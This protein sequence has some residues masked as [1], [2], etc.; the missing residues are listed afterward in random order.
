MSDNKIINRNKLFFKI[1]DAK[2][3]CPKTPFLGLTELEVMV[4][5]YELANKI[6]NWGNRLDIN[7][8][9]DLANSIKK[10]L[11]NYETNNN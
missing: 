3:N 7:F 4:I 5:D 6:E 10:F 9:K 8:R 1:S 2:K 11:K